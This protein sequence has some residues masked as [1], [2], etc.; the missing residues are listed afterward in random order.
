V[1]PDLLSRYVRTGKVKS[2]ARPIAVIGPD[3]ARGRAAAIA[4]GQQNRMFNYMELLYANQKTENTEWLSDS[5]VERTAAS[6]PCLNVP[7]LLAV[8]SSSAVTGVERR[9]DDLA[10]TNKST[11]TP[12]IFVGKAAA[13]YTGSPSAPQ[14]PKQPSQP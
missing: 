13:G 11:K 3:S 1:L 10:N 7:R 14:P 6:I 8:R 9:F 4:A 2:E 12:T 5:I